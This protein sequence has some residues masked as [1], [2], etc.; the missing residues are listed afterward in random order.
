MVYYTAA[1]W[2]WKIFI[3]ILEKSVKGDVRISEMLKELSKDPEFKN[4]MKV[5]AGFVPKVI[6]D[7]SRIPAERRKKRVKIGIIDENE[8]IQGAIDL[9][10]ERFSAKITIFREDD[11]ALYDPKQRASAALP[12]HSAIYL[13]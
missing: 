8:I 7:I 2:K 12:Y 5:V 3:D 9:L 1:S 13:E 6:K 11:L 10:S 4:N